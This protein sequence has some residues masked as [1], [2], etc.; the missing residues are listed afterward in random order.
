[1]QMNL[2]YLHKKLKLDNKDETIFAEG[3]VIAISD[4]GLIINAQEDHV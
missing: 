1:M 3:D 2:K 4:D